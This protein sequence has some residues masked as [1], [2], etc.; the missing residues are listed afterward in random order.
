MEELFVLVPS[1]QRHSAPK[2]GEA[3]RPLAELLNAVKLG[4]DAVLKPERLTDLESSSFASAALRM[5]WLGFG[6]MKSGPFLGFHWFI[7]VFV[8]VLGAA[9][10]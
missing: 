6:H 7:V 1:S 5:P 8:C 9:G 2:N 3:V 10:L 4:T